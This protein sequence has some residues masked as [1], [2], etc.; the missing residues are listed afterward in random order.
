MPLYDYDEDGYIVR[1]F[2]KIKSEGH[3]GILLAF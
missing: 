1:K 2:K 3:S